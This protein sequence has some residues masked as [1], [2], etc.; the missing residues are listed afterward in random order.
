[1]PRDIKKLN[2]KLYANTE[3]CLY[4][5]IINEKKSIIDIRNI[6][7][8]FIVLEDMEKNEFSKK[9]NQVVPTFN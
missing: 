6:I 5:L 8:S 2:L 3:T 7:K 1:M 4:L 9:I